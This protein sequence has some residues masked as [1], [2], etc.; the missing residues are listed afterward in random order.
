MHESK[1]RPWHL[2]LDAVQDVL[3]EELRGADTVRTLFD[4]VVDAAEKGVHRGF[5]L[6]Q[7]VE[8][9]HLANKPRVSRGQDRFFPRQILGLPVERV[10][11]QPRGLVVEVVAGGE[12]V[13]PAL[14]G[15][16]IE[17]VALHRATGCARHPVGKL[18]RGRH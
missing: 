8:R 2:G 1:F 17:E 11:Q 3:V 16:L 7:A 15:S 6:T 14:N 18:G 10:A 4:D 12:D 9:P 13:K 5:Q